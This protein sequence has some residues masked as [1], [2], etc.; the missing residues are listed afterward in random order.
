MILAYLATTLFVLVRF[1]QNQ[2]TQKKKKLIIDFKIIKAPILVPPKLLNSPCK[3]A[4]DC[5]VGLS[6]TDNLCSRKL[7]QSQIIYF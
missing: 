1:F 5:L 2:I 4:A 6:C 3:T 7:F